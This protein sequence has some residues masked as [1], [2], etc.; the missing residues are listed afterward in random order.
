MSRSF[1]PTAND[2]PRPIRAQVPFLA[3]I[4]APL[5]VFCADLRADQIEMQNG[6]HYSGTVLALNT[7]SV[8]LQNEVLGLVNLPRQKVAT[9]TLGAV[10]PANNLAQSGVQPNA[11]FRSTPVIATNVS[12]NLA[13]NQKI[14]GDTNVIKQVEEQFLTGASPEAKAKF[15]ALASGLM[16]GSV[17]VTDIRKE[18]KA[19]ADQLRAAKRDLGPEAGEAFDG[20]LAILDAFLQDSASES[21]PVSKTPTPLPKAKAPQAEE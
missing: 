16:N 21:A 9:I 12:H 1:V 11:K 7:N 4:C 18:A 2:F 19:A 8:V 20:Y 17:S 10:A 13:T 6:D 14:A 15:N 3:M 5:V